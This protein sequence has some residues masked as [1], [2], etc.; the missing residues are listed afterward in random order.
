MLARKNLKLRSNLGNSNGFADSIFVDDEHKPAEDQPVPMALE[1]IE[2]M[3]SESDQMEE[4]EMEDIME[5]P[6]LDIDASDE[7]NPLAVTEYIED[8]FSYYRKVE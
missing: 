6:I 8:L 5:E 7:N 1:Q 3:L 2:Q 4:V